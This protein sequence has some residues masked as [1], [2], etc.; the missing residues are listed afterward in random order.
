MRVIATISL[1]GSLVSSLVAC[2]PGPDGSEV[3]SLD[4]MT[5]DDGAALTQNHCGI[6]MTEKRVESLSSRD[7]AKLRRI[8]APTESLKYAAAGAL[9]AVPKPIQSVFFA[10]DG[11]LRVVK[12][13]ETL[14]STAGL[15]AA[16][17]KFAGEAQ[18]NV[19]G[20]WRLGQGKLEIIIKA[21]EDAIKHGL[22]RLMGYAY[23]QFFAERVA[24]LASAPSDIQKSIVNGTKRFR[25][26]REELGTALLGDLELRKASTRARFESFAKSDRDS[27]EDFV[28][29][30]SIDS[31]YCSP[32]SR[33]T[34]KK[35][36]PAT[37]RVFTQ[38][39]LNLLKD[40]GE[41]IK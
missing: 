17:L 24:N 5:R 3:Q 18:E 6:E 9:S 22:V 29:A 40:F 20:C 38:G 31:Y 26:Q 39:P 37:Y 2:K 32:Q 23:T 4:N 36:F 10:A 33:A 1:V 21:D 7:R 16:E 12:N 15:S 25:M 27:Y 8:V 11:I 28:F 41:P 13:P 35:N 30:E 19:E 14:C 34:M